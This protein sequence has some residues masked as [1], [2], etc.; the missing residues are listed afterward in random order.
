MLKSRLP[1]YSN[2]Q[3]LWRNSRMSCLTTAESLYNVLVFSAELIF[4]KDTHELV[5]VVR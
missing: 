3:K 4:E 1:R 2:P 5:Y